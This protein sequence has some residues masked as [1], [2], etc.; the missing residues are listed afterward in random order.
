[1]KHKIFTHDPPDQQTFHEMEI[2]DGDLSEYHPP[3]LDPHLVLLI[4]HTS[5]FSD[6]R[7]TSHRTNTAMHEDALT[8]GCP[9]YNAP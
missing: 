2:G 1:M 5:S 9:S 8:E 6:P 3:I 4:V 7:A